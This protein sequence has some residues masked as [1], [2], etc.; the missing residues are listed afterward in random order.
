MAVI[1]RLAVEDFRVLV[2]PCKSLPVFG[3]DIDLI[4]QTPRSE[5]ILDG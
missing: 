2:Q 3:G 4:A 1:P 5:M